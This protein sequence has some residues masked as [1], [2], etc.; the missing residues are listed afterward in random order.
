MRPREGLTAF[1]TD[2]GLAS[3]LTA[4]AAIL[5]R[6]WGEASILCEVELHTVLIQFHVGHLRDTL[7]LRPGRTPGTHHC[8]TSMR[9]RLRVLVISLKDLRRKSCKGSKFVNCIPTPK[10]E[11]APRQTDATKLTRQCFGHSFGHA[12]TNWHS[13]SYYRH[14]QSE[15]YVFCVCTALSLNFN[16]LLLLTTTCMS[17]L[18]QSLYTNGGK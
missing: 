18:Q 2:S 17:Y 7:R 10:P 8:A 5:N 3:A 15:E 12:A 1:A 11:N 14:E 13:K 16:G 9:A 6:R 4:A